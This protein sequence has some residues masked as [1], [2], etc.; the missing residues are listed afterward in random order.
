MITLRKLEDKNEEYI[1]LHKWCSKEFVYEWFEQRILSY[2]EIVNKY[3]NK[4]EQER[5]KLFIIQSNNEDIGFA[6]IYKYNNDLPVEATPNTYEYDLF[7]GEG[8]YLNKGIGKEVMDIMINKIRDEYKGDSILLRPFK[9]N[10]RS[11][12]CC[13]KCGFKEIYEYLG[14]DT[15]GNPEKYVVLIK[16]I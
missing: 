15:L 16:E 9:R 3:K 2:E 10:I 1:Q 5:Q 11:I 7:I 14:K 6:Q 8:E 4:L 12:K 13:L